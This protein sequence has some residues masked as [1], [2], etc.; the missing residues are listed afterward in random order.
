MVALERYKTVSE[1]ILDREP[2]EPVY[3]L[4]HE[5][6]D[7]I[8]RRF[9]EN[10]PGRVL[11]AVKV[12]PMPHTL[13]AL[14][15]SG[16]RYFD[17]ASLEEIRIVKETLPDAICYFMGPVRL[18]G[19]ATGAYEK[20]NVR[21]FVVD[22]MSALDILLG[23]LPEP[24][25]CMIFAR[26]VTPSVHSTYEFSSK[27]GASSEHTIEL[28]RAI[29]ASGALPAMA[30]NVGSQVLNPKAYKSAISMAK[31]T[32]AKTD[33][34]IH[35]MDIGGGYPVPYPGTGIQPLDDYFNTIKQA[36]DDLELDDDVIF[37]GEPGRALVAKG[38]SLVTQVL[39]RKNNQ[40]YLNDGIYGSFYEP[41][42]APEI[43]YPTRVY[44]K[45]GQP[46]DHSQE[47]NLY[48]PTCD[49]LD[50]LSA[51]FTLPRDIAVGDW[52]EFGMMGAY[53]YTNRTQF[54][55]FYPNATVLINGGNEGPPLTEIFGKGQSYSL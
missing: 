2:T 49:S 22:H 14:W 13:Q 34:K 30:Y 12:N 27:F 43:R 36:R 7:F 45:G 3:C 4:H 23:E 48:G 24:K 18:K 16:V 19:A 55:G 51:P 50:A 9:L 6:Q 5:T 17:T 21:H 39:L 11:Y 20:Y 26:M 37:L 53:T 29:A 15:N 52:I 32:L 35:Q 41:N 42:I 33:V 1:L 47:F 10:F 8:A 54:N 46:S 31:D 28:L 40:I 38:T 44:R 25:K